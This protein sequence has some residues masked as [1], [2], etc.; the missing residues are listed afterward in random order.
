M[1]ISFSVAQLDDGLSAGASPGWA[2][3]RHEAGQPDRF[4]SRIFL[5]EQ[6]AVEHAHRLSMQQVSSARKAAGL[7]YGVS[8]RFKN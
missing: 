2:V 4:I 8:S 6:D 7:P 3:I 5:R 1:S